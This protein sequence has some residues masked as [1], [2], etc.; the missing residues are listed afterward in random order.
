MR[1]AALVVAFVLAGAPALAAGDRFTPPPELAEI[2]AL[3]QPFA[4]ARALHDAG[5]LAEAAEAFRLLHERFPAV[6]L[7]YDRAV[8][9][10]KLGD[11]AAADDLYRRALAAASAPPD[12][13]LIAARLDRRGPAELRGVVAVFAKPAMRLSL[14]DGTPLG[15]TPW[16]GMLE[17]PKELVFAATGLSPAVKPVSLTPRDLTTLYYFSVDDPA[18]GR[19]TV[20]TRPPSAHVFLDGE[21]V[22][23]TPYSDDVPL[24]KHHVV[25][26]KDG[27]ADARRDVLLSPDDPEEAL[28][29]TL[30]P[31]A[32]PAP[33]PGGGGDPRPAR[34]SAPWK[35][36]CGGILV[37]GAI[38]VG[39]NIGNDGAPAAVG[40]A[41]MGTAALAFLVWGLASL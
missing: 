18:H 8:C 20:A 31:A 41:V 33:P 40:T 3:R 4:A 26:M 37:A 39:R 1:R 7:L 17:G 12:K 27:Y 13:A 34:S 19:L 24:G 36:V 35:L 11:H 23:R 16:N 38:N 28:D 21:P 25:V 9:L 32:G 10:E 29:L 14:A 5:K 22:G 6:G 15:R 30:Q 2:E